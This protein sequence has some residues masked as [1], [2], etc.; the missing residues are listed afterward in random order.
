MAAAGLGRLEDRT[1]EE[2]SRALEAVKLAIELGADVNAVN[3]DGQ[4]ALH[5][6]AYLGSNP[7]IQ[8]LA[9]KGAKLNLKDKYGRD[10][11]AYCRG[12]S[13]ASGLLTR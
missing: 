1:K 3:K 7:I 8:L 10:A 4:T 9:D 12:Q 5:A 11:A 2:E 6:A 13:R